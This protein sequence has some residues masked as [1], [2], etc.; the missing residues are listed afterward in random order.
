MTAHAAHRMWIR[1]LPALLA[2]AATGC[3]FADEEPA[4]H[5][6]ADAAVLT[7]GPD[8]AS[9]DVQA[10]VSDVRSSIEP[11]TL[12]TVAAL[13]V[14][15]RR[16]PDGLPFEVAQRTRDAGAAPARKFGARTLMIGMRTRAPD[17]TQYPC[18]ACHNRAAVVRDADRPADAH[19][20]IPTVHPSAAGGGCRTCHARADVG[21]L[22]LQDGDRVTMDHAYR[23]CAQC[24]FRQVD[25]WAAGGHGKRLD[26]W[27]GRRV[28][29][30]CTDCHDP[31]APALQ[32]RVPFRA[33][34]LEPA[35][36]N[37]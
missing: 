32:P 14:H 36:R 4:V 35:G 6:G 24:H 2:L 21:M 10:T 31:H 23:L 9:A 12:P 3:T 22:G 26:G 11:G 5:V 13:P 1:V 20:D 33:P 19:R 34:S 18:T 8:A 16:G 7:A 37:R 29:M 15:G 28:V 27:Q 30:G 17:L 25:E